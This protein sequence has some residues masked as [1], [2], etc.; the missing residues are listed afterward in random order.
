LE[1]LFALFV[2]E[3]PVFDRRKT[4]FHELV[5]DSSLLFGKHRH[6]APAAPAMVGL[7]HYQTGGDVPK[8]SKSEAK[9]TT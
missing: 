7:G 1:S 3:Q 9:P 2:G 4:F 6:G 5:N 8:S